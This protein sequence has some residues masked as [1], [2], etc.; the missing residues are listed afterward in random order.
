MRIDSLFV[1]AGVAPGIQ[2]AAVAAVCM[3]HELNRQKD[4]PSAGTSD[5]VS[6]N[7]SAAVVAV[8]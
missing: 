6:G 5:K 2:S 7:L 4:C 3:V 1:V 8:A